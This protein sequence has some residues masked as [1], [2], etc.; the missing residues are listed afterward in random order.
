[1][2]EQTSISTELEALRGLFEKHLGVRAPTLAK[3]VRR[4]G[5][6]LP[7]GLRTQAGI[8]VEAESYAAHPKLERRIDRGATDA[9]LGALTAYLKTQDLSKERTTRRLNTLA[10]VV[11]NLLVIAVLF[12]VVLRWRGF[13]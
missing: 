1:M 12:I 2:D 10:V 5:R 8:L 7:R 11:F 9:A 6:R 13:V 3:A 4:T